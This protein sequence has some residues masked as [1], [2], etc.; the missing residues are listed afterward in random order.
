VKVIQVKLRLY[1]GGDDDLIAFF[2]L[3]PPRLRAVMVKR[4][5]RSGAQTDAADPCDRGD[6]L[7]ALDALVT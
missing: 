4:A 7:L 5:L 3:I 2:S 1:E 6:D